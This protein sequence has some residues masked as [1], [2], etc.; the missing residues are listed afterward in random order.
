MFIC[1]RICVKLLLEAGALALC[2]RGSRFPLLALLFCLYLGSEICISI[3][4]SIYSS[5]YTYIRIYTHV[6]MN[7][8]YIYVYI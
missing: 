1:I 6:Y 2:V 8:I 4:L 3:Y 7:Y 5:V